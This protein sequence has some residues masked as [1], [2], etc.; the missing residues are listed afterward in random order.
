MSELLRNRSFRYLWLAGLLSTTGSEISRLGLVLYFVRER[1]SVAYLALLVALKT[2]PGALAAPAAGWIID[3]FSKRGVMIASDVA[4]MAC[5]LVILLWPHDWVIY[6]MAGVDSILAVF[7]E[8]ARTA[9]LPLIV[10]PRRIPEAN[11]LQQSMWNLTMIAGPMLGAE[12]FISAGLAVTLVLDALSFLASAV[13]VAFVRVR[14]VEWADGG[15]GSA[16]TGVREGWTYFLR[17]RLVRH[18]T[19]LIFVSMLCGGMWV[20]LAPFFIRDVLGGSDR[21]LGLQFGVFGLGGV[22]GGVLAPRLMSHVNKGSLVFMALLAE[23]AQFAMYALIPDVAASVAVLFFWGITVSII[24]VASYS[25]LQVHVEER[26]LGRVFS[27]VKQGENVAMLLAVLLAVALDGVLGSAVTFLVGGL[28]YVWI[29][30]VS[31]LTRGGRQ[32]LATP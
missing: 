17:N 14:R 13:L 1:D 5:L 7:F 22:V 31:S 24:A 9:T 21:I 15:V 2:L 29:V 28:C 10:E 11:G 18:L 6:A 19:T 8:P 30:A 3:R 23:G 26:F 12:L 16:L 27:M 25:I 32:L 4:R 20:P